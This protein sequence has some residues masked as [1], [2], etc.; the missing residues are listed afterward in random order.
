MAML[1]AETRQKE[2]AVGK[3]VG[4]VVVVVVECIALYASHVYGGS[5]S[6]GLAIFFASY[7]SGIWVL[8]R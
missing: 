8:S 6:S 4:I 3:I 1:T 2:E 5:V 7:G